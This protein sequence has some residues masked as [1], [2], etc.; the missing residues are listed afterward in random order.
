MNTMEKSQQISERNPINKTT[1]M[2]HEN[3]LLNLGFTRQISMN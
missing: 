3:T 1:E 2:A